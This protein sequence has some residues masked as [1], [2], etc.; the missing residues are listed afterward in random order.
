MEIAECSG[1]ENARILQMRFLRSTGRL[2]VAE[3]LPQKKL[4]AEGNVATRKKL[5]S[6]SLR[7]N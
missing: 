1:P 6:P 5:G 3:G 4:F 2:E 7:E